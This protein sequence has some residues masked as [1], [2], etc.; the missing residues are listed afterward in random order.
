MWLRLIAR[1]SLWHLG[2]LAAW[3]EEALPRFD[4]SALR[5][6][7]GAPLPYGVVRSF[8][9][10]E[11]RN[12]VEFVAEPGSSRIFIAQVNGEIYV[13]DSAMEGRAAEMIAD[14]RGATPGFFQL[15]G[16]ALSPDY[17]E[18]GL[19]YLAYVMVGSHPDGTRLVECQFD[20]ETDKLD[21][22]SRRLLFT[23]PSGG[24]NGTSLQF[25]PDGYLYISAG[26]GV[27]P[28]PPDVLRAGQD[29]SNVLSTIM[30]IDVDR[31]DPGLAYRIPPGNPFSD[32][33]GVRPEIWAY[34]FRN[35]WRMSFDR[36]TGELW[37]GDVGW[38][39]WELIYYV[40]R[41]GNYGWSVMEG[42]QP[43]NV[44]W[45][46]GPTPILPPIAE[47]S[48]AEARSIT[49]G[50]VYYG[51]RFPELRGA[52]I[53][54]DYE[55]GKIWALWHRRGERRA[56]KEIADSELRIIC[57]GQTHDGEI[58]IVDYAGGLYELRPSSGNATVADGLTVPRKLGDT[59]LFAATREQVPAP[60]LWPYDIKYPMW[61]DGLAAKRWLALPR[62]GVL[63]LGRNR[64]H[65]P[66]GA[67]I[68]KTLSTLDDGRPLETQVLQKR[69]G[70]WRAFSY[71]WNAEHT[72]AELVPPE[73]WR[74][75]VRV[76]AAP[77]RWRAWHF[78]SS[79]ECMV[80]HHAHVGG[81]LGLR[82]WQFG[83]A[84]RA[85]LNAW[86]VLPPSE[87]PRDGERREHDEMHPAR[88]YLEVNCASC[89][90]TN[91]G[92][93]VPMKLGRHL[94]KGKLAAIDV[95]PERG[96]F[97]ILQPRI[98]AP[99]QPERSTLYYRMAKLGSGRMPDLGSQVVD[100][101]G[102]SLIH[103]WIE[104][105]D[106]EADRRLT[107]GDAVSKALD[108]L[109][110]E[111]RAAICETDNPFIEALRG[112]PQR[113]GG[114][115]HVTAEEPGKDLPALAEMSGEVARGREL[116]LG[117][118]GALCLACHRLGSQGREFGPSL[119]G[120]G[121]RR[122]KVHLLESIVNPS[123]EIETVYVSYTVTTKDEQS[124]TG[125]IRHHDR[126][127]VVLRDAALREVRLP[128]DQI[129]TM[130]ARDVSA[131]PVGLAQAFPKGELADLLAFLQSLR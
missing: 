48:H 15:Y 46:R 19:V 1:A 105:L 33:A 67:I 97:G 51:T 34:G 131:M 125:L 115:S 113:H 88:T 20:P 86:G 78:P 123:K 81:V 39:T 117:A 77:E 41:G 75:M 70:S 106:P 100:E 112:E 5:G 73:G 59:G 101:K 10:Q 71:A 58:T 38:D 102:L 14:L 26:D 109:H 45:E 108:R 16:M 35:P 69:H 52:Y 25:G 29:C 9:G 11:F 79:S 87:Q 103:E 24:H 121:A 3:G 118:R 83:E 85:A 36:E 43:I 80:C 63:Q 94:P 120:I 8:P 66:E 17:L 98:I 127:G 56:L 91:G 22:D 126:D 53:Y 124:Y 27:G 76:E 104:S 119:D 110:R 7:L 60:G 130:T 62:G 82:S 116:L 114:E 65:L 84:E 12:P 89:H 18:N 61:S 44:T 57:F 23:W 55:T 50:H 122:A 49:G 93:L 128:V 47:H 111:G 64:G 30:R 72:E 6:D 96:D 21:L 68:V 95:L 37:V 13:F 54:G 42:R 4:D 32:T 2:L 74:R 90:R 92:G 40:R 107:E 31:R 28:N 99:G 129:V